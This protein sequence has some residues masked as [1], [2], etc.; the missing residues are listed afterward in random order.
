[1]KCRALR[2]L[3][4]VGSRE[5]KRYARKKGNGKV[6]SLVLDGSETRNVTDNVTRDTF[7]NLVSTASW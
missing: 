3:D 4:V 5:V 6:K 2:R 7:P 1:M